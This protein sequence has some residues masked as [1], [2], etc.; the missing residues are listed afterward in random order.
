[1]G[2]DECSALDDVA[3]L[4]AQLRE[5]RISNRV[6][7]ATIGEALGMAESGVSRLESNYYYST[8]LI[9]HLSAYATALGY[10]L[11]LVLVRDDTP[12]PADDRRIGATSSIT[13]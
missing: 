5:V 12:E 1:M 6:T 10:T 4:V 3:G 8:A 2:V 11:R 13:S 9:T 7:L